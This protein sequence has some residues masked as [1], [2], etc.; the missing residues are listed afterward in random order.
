M[1][2]TG[3][4]LIIR[5]ELEIK[6]AIKVNDILYAISEFDQWLRSEGKYNGR[7]Y[8]TDENSMEFPGYKKTVREKFNEFLSDSGI[9]LEELYP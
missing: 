9:S 3:K 1:I 4:I 2:N 6:Q 7:E 5:D 8:E